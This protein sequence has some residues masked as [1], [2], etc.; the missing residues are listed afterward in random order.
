MMD[1]VL[2]NCFE[3]KKTN[4]ENKILVG[5]SSQIIEMSKLKYDVHCRYYY[6]FFGCE[7]SIPV[8]QTKWN[9]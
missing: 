9:F 8:F 2:R 4:K 6:F 3:V 5:S 1:T 7:F